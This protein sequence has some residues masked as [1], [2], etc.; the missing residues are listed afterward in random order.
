MRSVIRSLG[1]TLLKLLDERRARR[2][3]YHRILNHHL[4]DVIR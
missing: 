3:L 4:R 1:T 2:E